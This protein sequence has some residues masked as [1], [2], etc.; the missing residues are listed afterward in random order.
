MSI[1]GFVLDLL[2]IALLGV[3]VYYVMRLH[4]RLE[5]IRSGR[6]DLETLLRDLVNNTASAERS[7]MDL[8]ENAGML[9]STL[10]KQ[11]TG[12]SRAKEELQYLLTS[13]DKVADTLMERIEKARTQTPAPRPST[14]ASRAEFREA[15]VSKPA[16]EPRAP[17]AAPSLASVPPV[18]SA[19]DT[20]AREAAENDLLR[21]I[22]KL[23]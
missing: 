19:P 9:S 7:L 11:I 22:E 13:A 6:H 12:A 14:D 15:L 21:A 18:T 4:K 1:A 5:V 3:T 8:R 10:D 2:L 20:T 16:P 23:R 17:A